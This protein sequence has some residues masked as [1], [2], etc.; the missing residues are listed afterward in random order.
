MWGMIFGGNL[1]GHRDRIT[2]S[3]TQYGRKNSVTFSRD[4]ASEAGDTH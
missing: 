2:G 3:L 1:Y 4:T